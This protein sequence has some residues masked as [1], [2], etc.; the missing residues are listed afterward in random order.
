MLGANCTVGER[1]DYRAADIPFPSPPFPAGLR[2][3]NPTILN[4]AGVNGAAQDNHSTPG[5][6]VKP[7]AAASVT[8]T[9]IY[10]YTCTCANSGNPVTIMGPINI[11][12]A[13]IMNANGSFRFEITK[14]GS[15]ATIN[16]LP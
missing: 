6:F 2:P 4:V 7:Y 8:A 14:S 9:Q 10:R 5:A 3:N 16:P 11:V 15:S 13:V 1:V 12:R